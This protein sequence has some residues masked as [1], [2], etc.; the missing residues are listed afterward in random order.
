MATLTFQLRPAKNKT[1]KIQ[2]IFQYGSGMD[3]RFRYSTG[4]SI[5]NKSSWNTKQQ[6][7]TSEKESN[8]NRINNKLGQLNLFVFDL[9]NKSKDEGF[10]LNKSLLKN[11]LDVFLK[12][13]KSIDA[14]TEKVV[15]EFL[16]FFEWFLAHYKKN[17]LPTTKKPLTYGTYKTYKNAYNILKGFENKNYN[18]TYKS[19]TLDFYDDFLNY[20]YNK[21]LSTNYIGTQIKILKTIMNAAF[22]KDFHDNLD[23]KKRYFVK[24]IEQVNNIYL[25]EDEL[26][27]IF[28]LDL[29]TV[30]TIIRNNTLRLTP[31]KLNSARDLFLIGA[32]TGLRISDYGRLTDDNILV[33]DGVKYLSIT[34][35]KTG[36]T[37]T[38][39][40][41]P[42]VN[43]I[44]K[45][46]NGKPPKSIPAQ[47][48]NYAIKEVGKLAGLNS[49]ETK[50]ITKGGKK[51]IKTIEKWK[52]ISS[53][54]SR[55]SFCTN[56]YKSGMATVDIMAISGHQTEKIF[57]N[58]LKISGL[59]KA[60]KIREYKFFNNNN[61]KIA[62]K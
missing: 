46:R 43:A 52:L 7:I 24:P 15:L 22:E 62:N 11:E 35:Q 20:L 16:P 12:K 60:K 33:V 5:Q 3:Y 26:L 47:H 17:A 49:I 55:R 1:Y 32:N 8:Q 2:L 48:L 36:S 50:T 57:Y 25:T 56:A 37:L 58:Y 9:Y 59:D 27:K 42:M 51:V 38:I 14:S 31:D 41:N 54:T 29:S 21:T 53:H 40:I 23:F 4:L 28:N 30:K 13:K 10:D 6:K 18:L 19:I 61:L 44:L 39:P 34:T 45:K